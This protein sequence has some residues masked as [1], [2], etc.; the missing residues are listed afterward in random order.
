MS[1]AT[2]SKNFSGSLI[3]LLEQAETFVKTTLK[4]DGE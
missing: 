2:D 1:E 4:V 3:K